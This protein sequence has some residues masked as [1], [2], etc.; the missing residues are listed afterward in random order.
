MNYDGL[1]NDKCLER[2]KI[3]IITEKDGYQMEGNAFSVFYLDNI[4]NHQE[5]EK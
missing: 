5:D 4:R 1:D 2:S 3:E